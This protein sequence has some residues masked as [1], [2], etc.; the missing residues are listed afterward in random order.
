[1]GTFSA[2]GM[3]WADVGRQAVF[4]NE[5]LGKLTYLKEVGVDNQ[6]PWIAG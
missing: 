3:E 2:K 1:M 4:I 5:I 6:D